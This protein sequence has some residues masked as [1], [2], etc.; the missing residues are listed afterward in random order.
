MSQGLTWIAGRRTPLLALVANAWFS[1]T[2]NGT[3]T[4]VVTKL[5]PTAGIRVHDSDGIVKAGT[6]LTVTISL[7][8]IEPGASGTVSLEWVRVSGELDDPT[9]G[10][11]GETALA[12]SFVIEGSKTPAGLST[13]ALIE[14]PEGTSE[15]EYTVSARISYDH[16]GTAYDGTA[17]PPTGTRDKTLTPTAKFTV[18]DPGMN[19][20]SATL[21]LGNSHDED[22]LTSASDVI[23]E[24]GVEAA[25]GGDVWLK[26]ETTNSLGEK[27][28]DGSLNTLTVIAPGATLAAHAATGAGTPAATALEGVDGGTNSLG[29]AT[30]S[31]VTQ[32]MFIKV[33]RPALRPSRARS[34]STPL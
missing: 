31:M 5:N 20:A 26:V 32:T 16:D 10:S 9:T 1:V 13:T 8:T 30:G 22:P 21:S 19:A 2:P 14:I 23:P 34:R 12:T 4:P 33:G 25:N 11:D 17:N 6:D 24:D 27:A 29:V 28:N 15:R 18:G 3:V 7:K